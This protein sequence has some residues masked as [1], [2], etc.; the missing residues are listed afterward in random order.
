[1]SKDWP[2]HPCAEIYFHRFNPHDS[3]IAFAQSRRFARDTGAS[4]VIMAEG[5][6]REHYRAIRD[7][8]YMEPLVLDWVNGMDID[9][10]P[11]PP[12][13]LARCPR[14]GGA[15]IFLNPSRSSD[16]EYPYITDPVSGSR[17]YPK[18]AVEVLYR[19][20]ASR[21]A[22]DPA[23][24]PV[25]VFTYDSVAQA[26]G[27]WRCTVE[28][29]NCDPPFHVTGDPCPSKAAAR[30]SACFK[31]C[32]ARFDL[33]LLP[34]TFFP[35][36]PMHTLPNGVLQR[37]DSALALA[38]SYPPT[39][40]LFWHNCL[41]A[42]PSRVF[43]PNVVVISGTSNS[44][45][46]K[47][48]LLLTRAPLFDIDPF[49]IFASQVESKVSLLPCAPLTL[50]VE[51]IELIFRYSIHI[52]RALT[53]KPWECPSGEL[54]YF[55][56]PVV[57]GSFANA[58][59]I[60]R[61]TP[62]EPLISWEEIDNLISRRVRPVNCGSPDEIAQDLAGGVIQDRHNE[63]TRRF[64][65]GRVCKDLNPLSLIIKDQVRSSSDLMLITWD[66][67]I[68][69]GKWLDRIIARVLQNA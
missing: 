59:D 66:A 22:G 64:E 57:A 28:I 3:L 60:T 43:Y 23:L 24:V 7:I 1:M 8:L 10:A 38:S 44:N 35:S 32:L 55:V 50:S 6:N 49:P 63:F 56:C 14:F 4:L 11:I 48:T 68:P 29:P 47:S 69:L 54:A 45:A 65:V 39:S 33:G 46:L 31:A 62:A 17:I 2:I 26:G 51:R 34:S 36:P 20:L 18:D 61:A 37:S 9:G 13:S 19:Y 15:P 53:N 25:K 40:P 27:L 58:S 42:A 5:G 16:Q 41:L 52:W 67:E 21:S 30:G 12:A